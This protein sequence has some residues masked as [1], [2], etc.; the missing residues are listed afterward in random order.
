MADRLEKISLGNKGSCRV[1]LC[2]IRKSNRARRINIR[3]ESS[4]KIILTLPRWASVQAGRAFLFQQRKW[5][6]KRIEKSP[7]VIDLTTHLQTGGQVWISSNP[8]TLNLVGL[9]NMGRSNYEICYDQITLN[10]PQ[11][12]SDTNEQVFS[13]LQ[14]LAKENLT[15]RVFILSNKFGLEVKKVRVGNQKSRWGS[16]S[17]R[18]TI[19]LN[20][21]LL[22]LNYS[23]GQY[24]ILH[25]L[26]HL[27]HLNHSLA[28]WQYLE[29]ICPGARIQ[30]RE[31]RSEG[32]K[33]IN[34]GR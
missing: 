24:V 18:G 2:L 34:L 33:I 22:L 16:C 27:K 15:D 10:I 20:W 1:V 14:N 13:F 17:S 5:L 11:N 6:E 29:S 19:S 26:A 23:L 31:L 28:F 25:E 12:S 3:I 30:D 9:D 7:P 32:K 8:R 21:R 4:E